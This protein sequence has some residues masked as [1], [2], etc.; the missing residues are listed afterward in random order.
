VKP[1]LRQAFTHLE[2]GGTSG[3]AGLVV[4][5]LPGADLQLG[6]NLDREMT[7]AANPDLAEHGPFTP[8]QVERLR[9]GELPDGEL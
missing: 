1:E 5:A 6:R 8:A 3:D 9:A 4:L 2:Q 7:P